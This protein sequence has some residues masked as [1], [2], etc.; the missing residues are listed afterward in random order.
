VSPHPTRP[1]FPF[2]IGPVKWSNAVEFHRTCPRFLFIQDARHLTCP[3]SPLANL[4]RFLF[5]Q[6]TR[7]LT[8][9]YVPFRPVPVLPCRTCTRF[10]VSAS[11]LRLVSEFRHLTC[12]PRHLRSVPRDVFPHPTRPRFPFVHS[13]WS[14]CHCWCAGNVAGENV[15][16]GQVECPKQDVTSDLSQLIL[17]SKPSGRRTSQGTGRMSELSKGRGSRYLTSPG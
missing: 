8:C 17:P 14:N 13:D 2:V 5:I 1:R 4:S 6:D 15:A 7:Q 12:P 10:A 16:R 9:P 11:T 3:L